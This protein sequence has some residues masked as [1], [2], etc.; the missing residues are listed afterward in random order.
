MDI[1]LA[2]AHSRMCFYIGQPQNN[3]SSYTNVTEVTGGLREAD[4]ILERI[5]EIE[6]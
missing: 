5:E 2:M 4:S 6:K 3:F 1:Y